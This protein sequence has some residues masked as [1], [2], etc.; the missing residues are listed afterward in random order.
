MLVTDDQLLY[1]SY[2]N[3]S[4]YSVMII[5]SLQ[6]SYIQERVLYWNTAV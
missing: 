4:L 1:I 3:I 6:L 2:G 5:S